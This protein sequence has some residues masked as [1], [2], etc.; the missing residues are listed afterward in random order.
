MKHE[1]RIVIITVVFYF[2]WVLTS[3]GGYYLNENVKTRNEKIYC[4]DPGGLFL[5]LPYLISKQQL[6][7]VIHQWDT[8]NDSG[9]EPT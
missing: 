6:I 2:F 1:P 8:F 9:M 4:W 3:V 7:T 5:L